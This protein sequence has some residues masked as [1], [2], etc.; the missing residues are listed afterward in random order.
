MP[1][2][3]ATGKVIFL[4]CHD[5]GTRYGPSS[6]QINVEAVVKLDTRPASE[7]YGFTMRDDGNRVAH[8]GM[9]DLLRDAFNAGWTTTLVYDIDEGKNNG[10]LVRVWV[11]KPVEPV[12]DFDA[13]DADRVVMAPLD[14]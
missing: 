10:L 14:G 12:F 2:F 4:R 6:D 13:L 9:F 11:T 5:V 8:Q 3:R 7:A 1:R